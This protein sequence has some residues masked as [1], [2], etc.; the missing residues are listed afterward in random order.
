MTDVLIGRNL[1]VVVSNSD[2]F[3]MSG[4]RC[5]CTRTLRYPVAISVERHGERRRP[6]ML[7]RQV[8]CAWC[9]TSL[10]PSQSLHPNLPRRCS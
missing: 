5:Y 9:N 10:P 6:D 1:S 3:W 2:I 7:L 8:L 4:Y